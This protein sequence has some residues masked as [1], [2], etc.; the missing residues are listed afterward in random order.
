MCASKLFGGP[1]SSPLVILSTAHPGKFLDSLKKANITS[2]KK[3]HVL[4]KVINKSE[5]SFSLEANQDQIFNFIERNN[6]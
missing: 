4:E 6:N 5:Y 3:H 2:F 1:I